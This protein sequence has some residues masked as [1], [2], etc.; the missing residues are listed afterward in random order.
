MFRLHFFLSFSFQMFWMLQ[1]EVFNKYRSK[2]VVLFA[3]AKHIAQTK[4]RK[5]NVPCY[6][7]L[8]V[9]WTK[10]LCEM[11]C[12]RITCVF[13]RIPI[14]YHFLI[15]VPWLPSFSISPFTLESYTINRLKKGAAAEDSSINQGGVQDR[16]NTIHWKNRNI[17]AS[18]YK[19]VF[20]T[21]IFN[22]NSHFR[23]MLPLLKVKASPRC[24]P[25]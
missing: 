9:I 17:F 1:K 18:V 8:I 22:E 7:R 19:S 10:I 15:I 20:S 11:K 24:T 3:N 4:R 14:S 13:H 2:C 16:S 6:L 25:L 23:T 5:G 12:F 21:Y